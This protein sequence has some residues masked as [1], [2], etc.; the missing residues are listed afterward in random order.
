MLRLLNLFSA[1]SAT[2]LL[3]TASCLAFSLNASADQVDYAKTVLH[4]FASTNTTNDGQHPDTGL[5]QTSDGALWGTTL[6]G[7]SAG[8]GTIFRYTADGKYSVVFNFGAEADCVMPQG[9]LTLGPDGDLY[10]V[11]YLGGDAN[12]GTVYKIAPSGDFTILHSFEGTDENDGAGPSASVTFGH[13]GKLY[14]TTTSEE[15]SD[16]TE[17]GTIFS[18]KPDGSDYVVQYRFTQANYATVGGLP[19]GTLTPANGSSPVFYGTTAEGGAGADDGQ[20]TLFAFTPGT[21]DGGGKLQILHSF[22]D[23]NVTDDGESP[24]AGR[25]AITSSGDIIGLTPY[26]SVSGSEGVI[27]E[28]APDG[29][30][31][32]IV[33]QFGSG[34]DGAF[35]LGGLT[36]G[37]DGAYYGAAEFGG[38][39]SFTGGVIFR[40]LPA[41][42]GFHYTV[43]YDFTGGQ[44]NG[45]VPEA[46]PFEDSD[47]NL[48]GTTY[49]NTTTNNGVG[50]YG[51]LYKLASSL[52]NPV[53]V[54][55]LN[56]SPGTVIG[57]QMNSTATVTL[58]KP[59]GSNGAVIN[60]YAGKLNS[61]GSDNA[62]SVPTSVTIP[63]G[64]EL[65][66]FTITT[67][68][69]SSTT[70]EQIAASYNATSGIATLIIN[71]P[72]GNP[73]LKSVV[74]SPTSTEGGTSTTAN[75]VYLYGDA[76]ATTPV[77]LTSS[78]TSVATVPSTVTVQSGFSSHVF[79][80]NTKAVTTT[81]TVTITA[82]S[83]GVTQTATL[84]VIP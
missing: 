20:G 57:G 60:L 15:D 76:S 4:Q 23:A 30:S 5:V 54:A 28:C 48:I 66:T 10:G 3:L 6:E 36:L 45:A 26:G 31:Y 81:K 7:G 70:D 47:G 11:T 53:K 29:S 16:S 9:T 42:S 80:V 21:T 35:P 62:A 67:N 49:Y 1:L 2:A 33:H 74:L 38:N 19:E 43:V 39:G 79:T 68:A 82:T 22:P 73:S 72:S 83:A 44:G 63:T 77:T 52:P 50:G 46:K 17:T 41:G 51:T 14:G 40:L 59:A 64:A 65:A 37:S 13:D 78:D 18:M 71:P 25:V 84:T 75:R 34:K 58:N 32:T 8:D 12:D 61:S 24:G 55:S 27:Y 69:V 56:V